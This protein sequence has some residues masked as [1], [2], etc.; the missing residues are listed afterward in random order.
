MHKLY[1]TKTILDTHS[2][3]LAADGTLSNRV[4][5]PFDS[6]PV[7]PLG[8]TEGVATT[9]SDLSPVIVAIK[10]ADWLWLENPSNSRVSE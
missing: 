6:A 8:G 2:D 10:S 1:L 5:F 7:A 9:C 4:T 3:F